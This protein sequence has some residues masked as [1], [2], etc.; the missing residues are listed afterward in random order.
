MDVNTLL[1]YRSLKTLLKTAQLSELN[2]IK[3]NLEQLRLELEA[4]EQQQQAEKAQ[5][6]AKFLAVE[7]YIASQGLTVDQ[8]VAHITGAPK[9]KAK[10]NRP[11]MKPKY[12]FTA[13][14]GNVHEWTGQ[15]KMPNAFK[16]LLEAEGKDKEDFRIKE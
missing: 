10:T 11:P 7:A 9:K 3:E 8:F 15:G 13:L 14:D 6:E 1:N 4:Q 5:L 2:K 16:Q 12:R